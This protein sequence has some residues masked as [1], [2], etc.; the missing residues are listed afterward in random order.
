MEEGI[1]T[2]KR[3]ASMM[4]IFFTTS[5][6][7]LWKECCITIVTRFL[8]GSVTKDHMILLD[9]GLDLMK[10]VCACYLEKR[11]RVFIEHERE[12]TKKFISLNFL[13]FNL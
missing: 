8:M 1:R 12:R 9:T 2:K 11:L 5:W 3:K 7:S 13:F 10:C 6:K 4:V